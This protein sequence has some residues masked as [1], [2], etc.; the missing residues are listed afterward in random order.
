MKFLF[1]AIICLTCFGCKYSQKKT[2][3]TNDFKYSA[4][5]W[6]INPTVGSFE[7]YLDH[8]IDIDKTGHYILIRHD[9]FKDT[10]KCFAGE[11]NDTIRSLI[12]NI[13]LIDTFKTDYRKLGDPII[14]DGFEYCF[15]YQKP[16]STPIKILFIPMNAPK[17]LKNLSLLLDSLI[18]SATNRSIDTLN[19]SNYSLELKIF[20]L[21]VSDPLPKLK[22]DTTKFVPPK[23]SY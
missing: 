23:I 14:Y 16:K 17:K 21:S 19:F 10:L 18:Y 15:D 9:N 11:I 5:N 7:F 20:Y 6:Y 8:Y 22:L 12:N 2:I 4:Y 13:F 1:F 3:L